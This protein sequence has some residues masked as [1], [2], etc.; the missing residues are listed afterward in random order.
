M[1]YLVA[2]LLLAALVFWP[3]ERLW[4]VTLFLFGP[5]WVFALPLALLLPAAAFVDRRFAAALVVVPALLPGLWRRV[6]REVSRPA[7]DYQT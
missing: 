3:S 2:L 7:K 1:A 6:S 5:R 4:P